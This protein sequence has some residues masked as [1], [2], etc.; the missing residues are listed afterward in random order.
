MRKLQHT[1]VIAAFTLI[2]LLVTVAIVSIATGV[3]LVS[4]G[5]NRTSEQLENAARQVAGAFREAQNYALTGYQGVT[6]T[7]PCRF[8]VAWGGTSYSTT[9]SY[10]DGAGACTQTSSLRSYQL[11]DGVVFSGT[12]SFYFTLPHATIVPA[13]NVTVPVVKGG[14]THVVC[15]SSTGLIN[16]YDGSSCP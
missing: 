12:G 9:Y 5:N 4:S 7:D 2:E 8:T 1:S 16:N 11:G 14:S 15:V 13:A 10:K 3:L 6:G